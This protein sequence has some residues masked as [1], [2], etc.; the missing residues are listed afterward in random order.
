M[1]PIRQ[2]DNHL[3]A[4][5][6]FLL[7]FRG[8]RKIYHRCLSFYTIKETFIMYF[9]MNTLLGGFSSQKPQKYLIDRGDEKSLLFIAYLKKGGQRLFLFYRFISYLITILNSL[10]ITK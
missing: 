2:I 4:I 9:K 5:K 8:Y 7:D 10:S 6:I 3:I 1:R